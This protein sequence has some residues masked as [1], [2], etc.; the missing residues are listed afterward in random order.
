VRKTWNFHGGIH[1]PE[2]KLQSLGQPITD[3][4]VPAELVLPVSQ[5]I[6]APAEPV[7]TVGDRV[8]KGQIIALPKGFVSI[9][10]HAPSSGTVTAIEER[11]I[12]HPSGYS[13]LSHSRCWYRRYGRRGLSHCGQAF[14]QA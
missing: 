9:P 3:A 12:A 14:G 11:R 5:H 13:A 6:G 8:L 7:V 1:P 2:N 10:K 4:G